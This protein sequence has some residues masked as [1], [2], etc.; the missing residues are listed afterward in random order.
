MSGQTHDLTVGP[1]KPPETRY[2]LYSLDHATS[3][4]RHSP[5]AIDIFAGIL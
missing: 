2:I 4:L 3:L 1:H 5:F